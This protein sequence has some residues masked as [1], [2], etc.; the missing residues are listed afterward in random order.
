MTGFGIRAHCEFG[1]GLSE[2]GSD[3]VGKPSVDRWVIE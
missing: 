1:V 2:R 3:R